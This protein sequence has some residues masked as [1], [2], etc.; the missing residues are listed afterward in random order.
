[1]FAVDLGGADTKA[2]RLN[3][4]GRAE[5]SLRR[6]APSPVLVLPTRHSDGAIG[7]LARPAA[8]L[9]SL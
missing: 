8:P 3:V 4:E 7:G 2:A 6:A 1:V 5:G 9:F